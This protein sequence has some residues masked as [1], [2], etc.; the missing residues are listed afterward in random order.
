MVVVII[1]ILAA[2]LLPVIEKART[3]SRQTQCVS[4]MRQIGLAY[5][6]FANE[7]D[8]RFP[9]QVPTNQGGTLEFVQAGERMGGGIQFAYRHFQSISNDLQN[10]KLLVCPADQ[11][12][13]A[14]LFSELQNGNVSFFVGV[15]AEY[16]KPDSIL[17]GDGNIAGE[18]DAGS[19]LHLSGQQAAYWTQAGHNGRGNLLF[20]DSHVE[21]TTKAGLNYALAQQ[22]SPVSAWLPVGFAT[23]SGKG[24]GGSGSAGGGGGSGSGGGGSSGGGGGGGSSRGSSG[25]AAVQNYFQAP[26]STPSG[27]PEPVVSTPPA[28]VPQTKPPLNEPA[29]APPMAAA[30]AEPAAKPAPQAPASVAGKVPDLAKAEPA[31]TSA[32]QMPVNMFM[33]FMKPERC[34][35]CWVII[36]VLGL[37]TAFLLG[38]EIRRRRAHHRPTAA[39]G[40]LRS[41]RSRS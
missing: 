31:A 10:P 41:F 19:I 23:A 21:Q 6:M 11:K 8:S 16:S 3:R 32:G 39:G 2:L 20:A 13:P 15:S 17:A 5:Q 1:F 30:A 40:G 38:M 36:L 25:F 12:S 33:V 14:A 34:W 26:N 22:K 37:T 4:Q 24:G 29:P 27:S 7:H 18:G 9:F 28:P 35:Y